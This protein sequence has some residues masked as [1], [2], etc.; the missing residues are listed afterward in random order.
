MDSELKR[1]EHNEQPKASRSAETRERRKPG[2]RPGTEE[3]RR[4]GLAAAAKLGSEF[5]RRI[6]KKGGAESK[7]RYGTEHFA[8]IGR[9]GGESTKRRLGHEHYARIGKIGGKRTNSPRQEP[10]E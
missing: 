9:Q 10:T 1:P 6:G 4:G 8:R 2:P 3:A 5:Y 7:A